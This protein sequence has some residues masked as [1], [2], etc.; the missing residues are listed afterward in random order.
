MKVS[1][2]EKK[3]RHLILKK[4][5]IIRLL[6]LSLLYLIIAVVCKYQNLQKL[7]FGLGKITL[8]YYSKAKNGCWTLRNKY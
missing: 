5:D 6:I 2:N 8:G 4:I 7:C 3:N 1:F